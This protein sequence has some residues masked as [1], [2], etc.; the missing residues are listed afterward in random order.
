[1]GREASGETPRPAPPA[2]QEWSDPDVTAVARPLRDNPRPGRHVPTPPPAPAPSPEETAVAPVQDWYRQETF[3]PPAPQAPDQQLAPSA[4]R[5]FDWNDPGAAAAPA[6]Q[7]LGRTSSRGELHEARHDDYPPARGRSAAFEP[8]Y[9]DEAY[10]DFGP[11]ESYQDPYAAYPPGEH[12]GHDKPRIGVWQVLGSTLLVL[13]LV[14]G[15]FT[16]YTY[17]HLKSNI[18]TVSLE[19]S[20]D[21]GPKEPINILVMGSD[22]RDCKGCN[23]DGLTKDGQRSDTNILLHL[24]A[25]RKFAYGVSI[26]RDTMVDRPSCNR[27]EGGKA[28]AADYVRWNEAYSTAGPTCTIAQVESVADDMCGAKCDVQVNHVVVVDFSSFKGMVDAIDG[29]DVCLPQ[30]VDDPYTGA[31]FDAGDQTLSGKQALN[32]VR[33]R[34]GLGDGGDLDRSKRQQAFIG[35]MAAKLL[36]GDT[37]SSPTKVLG[38]L[39]AATK[40]LTMDEGL[41]DN[42]DSMAKIG[43]GFQSVGMENIKFLTIP[44]VPDPDNPEATVVLDEEK[45]KNVF[46]AIANDKPLTKK[47]AAGALDAGQASGAKKSEGSGDEGSDGETADPAPTGEAESG[48]TT[49]DASDGASSGASEEELDQIA[50]DAKAARDRAGLC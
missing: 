28:A 7:P 32:Y 21:V 6:D 40:G 8:G 11:R 29:V 48:E 31:H 34:H 22:S 26:P 43:S 47:I 24:S 39:N 18:D 42:L 37:L 45:A 30:E 44:T 35:S 10:D 4:A 49:G 3:P 13:A 23:V 9:G 25:N 15:L 41:K 5:E 12:D 1:M 20:G 2:P 27:E 46:K 14:V 17:R 38:F 16:V 33:L 50:E 36:S 19:G